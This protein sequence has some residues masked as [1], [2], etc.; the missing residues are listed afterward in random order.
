[1]RHKQG[2][3]RRIPPRVMRLLT[4]Q[5][6]CRSM[7]GISP[8][9]IPPAVP[10]LRAGARFGSCWRCKP[11]AFG[12]THQEL[13]RLSLLPPAAHINE[14]D[15]HTGGLRRRSQSTVSATSSGWPLRPSGTR[16]TSF[17]DAAFLA[18]GVVDPVSIRPGRTALTRMP[19]GPIS[20]A[21]PC[22][23]VSMAPLEA[24]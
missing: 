14:A 22:V 7:S 4:G 16:W 20:R 13:S 3:H 2:R 6:C 1:M 5:V 15:R 12:A 24:A 19:C 23:K 8:A 17:F 11:V 21:S 9:C 18:R 10:G